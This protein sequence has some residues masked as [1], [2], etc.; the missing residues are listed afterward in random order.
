[1]DESTSKQL[2]DIYLKEYNSLKG[3]AVSRIGFRDNLLY[4]NLTTIGAVI[5][6]AANKPAHYYALLIIPWICFILGWTYI[7]NDQKIS[8]IGHYLRHELTD[9]INALLG[10]QQGETLFGWEIAHRSDEKRVGRKVV[11]F[12][13]DELT[14]CISG[15]I[16]TGAFW[17][18]VPDLPGNLKLLT[19]GE[20]ILLL[21]LGVE[22]FF[23]ADF[24]KGE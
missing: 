16:T 22:L 12:V 24:K 19:V 13:V 2:L 21:L 14:F 17:M 15:L 20:F 7:V 5:S 1:M 6:Y 23:Y 10:Q 11:Q 18:L 9:K 8:A 3:E 4:V